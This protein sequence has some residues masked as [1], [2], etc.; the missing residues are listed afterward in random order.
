MKAQQYTSH[1]L[2]IRPV[3]F[4]YNV[5]TAV[6]NY[7]QEATSNPQSKALQEFDAMVEKLRLHG[8]NVMVVDDTP[9]PY[10]P[11][12]IFPNNWVSFHQ[13]GKVI[14]YPMFAVNRREERRMDVLEYIESEGFEIAKVIDYSPYELEDKFLEGTGS[15]IIDRENNIAYASVSIRTNPELFLQF[16]E[17][18]AYQPILFHSFQTVK[19]EREM[20]YH[21]NVMMCIADRYAV[22]CLDAIDNKEEKKTL[23]DSLEGNGKEVISITEE[24]MH[25]FAGNMLQVAGRDHQPYLVMSQSAYNSLSEEQ[26][27]ALEKYNP[28]ISV[29]IPTI[30]TNGGGSARCMMAEVFLP[31]Q[32]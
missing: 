18:N 19:G 14:L 16:C 28:I 5:E 21:T 20:I 31:R 29:S 1:I 10:T 15:I 11:D 26:I 7:F 12:S 9:E 8:V 25:Q 32:K 6:N 2:M 27:V 3:N 24:Q 17:E 30:E 4:N 22:I 23:I 13:S